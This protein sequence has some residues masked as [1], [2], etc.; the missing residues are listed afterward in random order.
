MQGFHFSTK[1]GTYIHLIDVPDKTHVLGGGDKDYKMHHKCYMGP[2]G[3]K[4][5]IQTEI[6]MDI[7]S[8]GL[9]MTTTV[10]KY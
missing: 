10:G 4:K 9:S 8:K 5:H 6:T 3:F 2:Y 7:H 1:P